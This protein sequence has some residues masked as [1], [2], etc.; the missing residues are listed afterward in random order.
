MAS[1]N[2][3]QGPRSPR[4]FKEPA[5][6]PHTEAVRVLWGDDEARHVVDLV[7]ARGHRISSVTFTLS[8]GGYFRA[9][10]GWKPFYDLHRF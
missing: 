8:P 6:V 2:P 7:Y 3:V 1:Q 5:L 4:D 9:S 10:K